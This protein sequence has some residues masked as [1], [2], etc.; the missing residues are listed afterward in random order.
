[1]NFIKKVKIKILDFFFKLLGYDNYKWCLA[2]IQFNKKF[3]ENLNYKIILPPKGK[4]W[5]DPFIINFKKK[6][7]V[8]FEEYD[9][10]IQRGHIC[11]AEIKNN[12]LVKKKIILKKK[13][14]MSYPNV[15][16]SGGNYFMIPETCSNKSVE[17]YK[18]TNFP[19]KWKL[20]KKLLSNK[21]IVDTN[22]Y[23]KKNV[24][25]VFVNEK[26][27]NEDTFAFNK[28]LNIYIKK[29]L[30][31]DRFVEHK[32]NPVILNNFKGRNAGQIFKIKKKSFR[33]SQINSFNKNYGYGLAISEIKKITSTNYRETTVKTLYPKMLNNKNICGI[34]HISKI[35]ENLFMIDICFRRFKS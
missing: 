5:A 22:I 4:F 16:S 15:F 14:H 31:D 6:K 24:C 11:C 25:Y 9:Y 2:I 1:M 3:K 17:L 34:H 18:S 32:N 20:H 28:R 21:E 10:K 30:L 33:P 26:Y 27:E 35:N 29:N 8:F 13:Y 23:F 19:Y 12:E 7:F